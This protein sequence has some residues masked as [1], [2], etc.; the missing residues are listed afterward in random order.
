MCEAR[1]DPRPRSGRHSTL[2]YDTGDGASGEVSMKE[3]ARLLREGSIK[4]STDVWAT[5][6]ADWTEF[7]V[8]KRDFGFL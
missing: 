2:L 6:M 4:D 5:G 7:G 3:V 1:P 8:C